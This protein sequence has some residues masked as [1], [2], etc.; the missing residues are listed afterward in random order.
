[1]HT[2]HSL[3]SCLKLDFLNLRKRKNGCKVLVKSSI[4]KFFNF[5][6]MHVTEDRR[7]KGASR[8]GVGWQ[9]K[10][11][12]YLMVICIKTKLITECI[13]KGYTVTN[14]TCMKYKFVMLCMSMCLVVYCPYCLPPTSGGQAG[15]K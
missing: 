6:F 8:Y 5:S 2:F 1:M 4:I 3:H 9:T 14:H 13:I 11:I 15:N 10:Y 7:L 12:A